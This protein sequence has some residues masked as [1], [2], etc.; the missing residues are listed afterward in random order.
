MSDA[1]IKFSIP[2][3]T[4]G[5]YLNEDILKKIDTLAKKIVLESNALPHIESEIR[6]STDKGRS[7]SAIDIPTL[8]KKIEGIDEKINSFSIRHETI[9]RKTAIQIVFDKKG[10][11][12]INAYGTQTD[13]EFNLQRI[14]MEINVCDQEYHWLIQKVTTSKFLRATPITIF[15]SLSM[16]TMICIFYYFY[17]KSIGI[18]ID[19][20]LIIH[21]SLQ[22]VKDVEKAI[23]SDSVSEKLNAILKG[24]LRNFSNVTEVLKDISLKIRFLSISTFIVAV[25]LF[26]QYKLKKL[27]PIYFF[28]FGHQIGQYEKLVKKR[29]IWIV[30]IILAFAVNIISGIFVSFF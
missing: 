25:A 22:Y 21:D 11:V 10:E 5:L 15:F 12:K 7:I 19:N 4:R 9:N 23:R 20:T 14:K 2:I 28:E 26:L 1:V 18:D 13:L 8:L 24:E 17:A 6:A 16:I 30:G 3:N 29:E 27:F